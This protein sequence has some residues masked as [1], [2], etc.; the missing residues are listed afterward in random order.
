MK[1]DADRKHTKLIP[2][3]SRNQARIGVRSGIISARGTQRT[4][5]GLKFPVD[6]NFR[7]NLLC[8]NVSGM[9]PVLR[10]HVGESSLVSAVTRPVG[11]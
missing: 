7:G 4:P 8:L 9:C 10:E 6:Y 5:V 3:S 1:H 11:G 2:N